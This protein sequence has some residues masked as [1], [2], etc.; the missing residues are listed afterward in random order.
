MDTAATTL[1]ERPKTIATGIGAGALYPLTVICPNCR[2]GHLDTP[3]RNGMERCR[4]CDA[5]LA[6]SA[7]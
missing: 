7:A 5:L 1:A 4:S 6:G 2:R 3:G